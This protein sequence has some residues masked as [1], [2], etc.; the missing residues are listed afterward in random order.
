MPGHCTL[1][2]RYHTMNSAQERAQE[3]RQRYRL[4]HPHDI[5]RVLRAEK[6]SVIRVPFVGRLDE[7]V[8]H[9]WIGI[10]ASLRDARRVRELLAHALGHYLLHSGNQIAWYWEGDRIRAS[11][12]ERQAWV[13]AYE[14]LMPA[15]RLEE[16]LRK[17]MG[18]EEI[19]EYFD[20]TEE[21]YRDRK[22]AFKEEWTGGAA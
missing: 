3:I 17:Q 7:V 9:N 2:Q 6:L 15:R 16:F 12:A 13:F 5:E 18:D 10:R 4:C 21:F 8:A 22:Q 11:Q 1:A 14:L 19:R 20:V